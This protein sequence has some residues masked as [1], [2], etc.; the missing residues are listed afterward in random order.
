LLADDPTGNDETVIGVIGGYEQGGLT[1]SVSY[2]AKF[3]T[4]MATLYQTAEAAGG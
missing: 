2:A 3:S 4:R 1:A